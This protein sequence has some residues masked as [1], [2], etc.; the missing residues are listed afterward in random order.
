MRKEVVM[1]KRSHTSW[2]KKIRVLSDP[3]EGVC[4]LSPTLS[5]ET[6]LEGG[7]MQSGQRNPLEIDSTL[8]LIFNELPDS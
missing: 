7:S 3:K 1:V 8:S 2:P 5:T 6:E 4:S